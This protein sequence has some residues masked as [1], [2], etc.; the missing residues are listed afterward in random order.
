MRI[1]FLKNDTFYSAK[2]S[3]A[4]KSIRLEYAET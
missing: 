3:L 2:L 4:E 1:R